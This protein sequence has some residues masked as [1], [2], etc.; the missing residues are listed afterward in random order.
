MKGFFLSVLRIVLAVLV[1]GIIGLAAIKYFSDKSSAVTQPEIDAARGH[2]PVATTPTANP[3][4]EDTKRAEEEYLQR[5]TQQP[6]VSVKQ[7]VYD[8]EENKLNADAKYKGKT[9]RL[10][11]L[12]ESVDGSNSMVLKTF[13]TDTKN[14]NVDPVGALQEGMDNEMARVDLS[15]HDSARSVLPTLRKGQRLDLLCTG[16]GH[17]IGYPD[18]KNCVFISIDKI[19]TPQEVRAKKFAEDMRA[20]QRDAEAAEQAQ[21]QAYADKVAKGLIECTG[22][23][24]S[25]VCYDKTAAN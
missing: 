25:R 13:P 10:Q 17:G 18:F 5:A 15:F 16:D 6:V 12:M 19:L 23:G 14:E 20:R 9:I 7:V 3:T 24:D 4:P 8:Y 2:D 22:E 21:K 11:G 1:L